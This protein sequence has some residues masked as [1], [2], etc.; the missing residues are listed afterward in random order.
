[1]DTMILAVITAVVAVVLV[2]PAVA[3]GACI[4]ARKVR[5]LAVLL[6]SR[7]E[8]TSNELGG[9]LWHLQDARHALGL[10]KAEVA[11]LKTQLEAA[12]RRGETRRLQQVRVAGEVAMILDQRKALLA[13]EA[14]LQSV[15]ASYGLEIDKLRNEAAS[16]RKQRGFLVS[17]RNSLI[18]SARGLTADAEGASADAVAL[19]A[20]NSAL[21][22]ERAQAIQSL[23]AAN[24]RVKAL[25]AFIER[26]Y[27]PVDECEIGSSEVW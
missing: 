23:N 8:A 7:L 24:S 25:E 4:D 16:L 10:L 13:Q 9:A 27:G 3:V 22:S 26:A 2:G 1:M 19:R 21:L 5:A 6:R 20:L 18:D 11:L 17:Q 14:H 15:V 12:K